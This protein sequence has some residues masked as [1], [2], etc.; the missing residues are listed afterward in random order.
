[1]FGTAFLIVTISIFSFSKADLIGDRLLN[2]VHSEV[3]SIDRLPIE[4]TGASTIICGGNVCGKNEICKTL[5]GNKGKE[6]TCREGYSRDASKQCERNSITIV[7][8]TSGPTAIEL[9]GDPVPF[10]IEG[11]LNVHLPQNTVSLKIVRNSSS[12][13]ANYTY[14]W[15]VLDGGGFGSADTYTEPVLTLSGLKEGV[16]RLR[17][18]VSDDSARSYRDVSVSV[19]SEK[20]PN[21][22]PVAVIRP[23]S[24]VHA[25]EGSRVVLDAEGSSDEDD[26]HLDFEWKL[27]NGPAVQ[28]PAM[29]AAI[30]RLDN[31]HVG[32]SD[33]DDSHLDFEWKLLNG[34]AVQLPAM[35]AAILRLDNLHVGNYSFGLTVKDRDGATDHGTVDVIVSAK[36]DDPPKAQ[37]SQ[38]G[39]QVSRSTIDVR[40]PTKTLLLCANTSTDDYGI[41]SY[42]WFR[43]DNL[44]TQLAVDYAG[45]STSVL[46][47]TNLQANEKFGP[48]VF[49]LE[50]SDASGQT[51]SA[52]ISILVNKAVNQPPQPDAGGNQTIQL[53]TAS[54]VLNGNV[55]D[56][57]EVVGYE[58]TQIS[59]LHIGSSTSVL[60]LTNLQA[61]EKFGPYVFR[62]EVSDASGQTDSATI[63]I[64]VNKAV[65]QPPQPDA[66][67]NQT[68]QLPTASAVLN[69]NVKDDGEV[70]GY[71]WT[72]I[73]GPNQVV[74]VNGDK[75]KCTISGFEEGIYQFRLNV[76]DDGGLSATDDT[77]VIVIRSKNEPPV[78]HARNVTVYLPANLAIL[79]GTESSDDAGIVRY[80][81]TPHDDVPACIMFL[82]SSSRQPIA[83]LSGL[84]PGVF[85]FDLTVADHSNAQDSITISLTVIAGEEQLNSVEL[86][87]EHNFSDITYRLRSKLEGRLATALAFQIPEAVRV[88]VC[89][90]DFAQDPTSGRVRVVFHTEFTNSTSNELKGSRGRTMV[91]PAV[92]AVAILRNEAN[93]IRD[94]HI[95]SINTLY[96][97]LD[98][99]G[100]GRC[101]NYSKECECDRY[102]MPN[103]FTYLFEGS[104]LDCSWSVL[105]FGLF[106]FVTSIFA[107]SCI[108]VRF[109][110]RTELELS[111]WSST[112]NMKEPGSSYSLLMPSESLSSECETEQ[113]TTNANR[114]AM[115]DE[116]GVELRERANSLPFIE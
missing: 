25:V 49:R 12:D 105:Y 35:N 113:S 9:K 51:D 111:D 17:A 28:L 27:L 29:N 82:G 4:A 42:K 8:T 116:N 34:P 1:M 22:P 109:K 101:S 78:A 80:A 68:I 106:L 32:S 84:V 87:M 71:E 21:K 40:L 41:T 115:S 15:E 98:C 97:M 11:P 10:H 7:E 67:G 88:D 57:G 103:L 65:N 3:T 38:C 55:K 47:L 20:K 108:V 19:L 100:H 72:Q 58:W 45:S 59:F 70:V 48:Y 86:Y 69:G 33:E 81:W 31:L 60:T 13:F 16:I 64:L 54:A 93:M 66:G 43:V 5:A 30:L 73:S 6:C 85:H 56:D 90:S 62:L 46:T 76:T 52:T 95:D 23:A 94:F 83:M 50:V 26:S 99:S 92:R 114:R 18:T 89:F 2:E 79:N 77:F 96:C 91:V 63:S 14:Y 75:S 112:K 74:I 110:Y 104:K 107:I 44:I 39:E 61:N 102:W 36:R 24:P 53:P 37:I